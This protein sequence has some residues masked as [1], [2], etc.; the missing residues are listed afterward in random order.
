MTTPPL[1]PKPLPPNGKIAFI[2]PSNRI[3]YV[4]P[5]PLSRSRA[6]L[7]SLGYTVTIIFAPKGEEQDL[8]ASDGANIEACINNRLSEI[9][10]A[11]SDP[12][13]DAIFCTIGGSLMTELVPRLVRD[14]SLHDTVRRNPKI[15]VGYSDITILHWALSQT[16][17]LRTFYGPCPVTELGEAA[18][19]TSS[20]VASFPRRSVARS[21]DTDDGYLQDFNL[22]HLLRCLTSLSPLGPVPRSRFYA[23]LLPPYFF[24]F[25]K[26]ATAAPRSLLPSPPYTWLRPGRAEGLLFGGCLTILPRILS[27]PSL[28]PRSWA[29]KILFLESATADA[30]LSRGAPVAKIRQAVADI[31]AHGV[32]DEIAGL[33]VGRPYGY[34]TDAARAEY[35]AVFRGL[36]CRGRLAKRGFPILMNVDIGHTSPMVT[37]PFGALAALD[38][39][40]DRFEILEAGVAA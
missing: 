30:D 40:G 25:S 24:T 26:T 18:T 37:L 17:G 28:A 36:L 16:T 13:V 38:S 19:S 20:S 39:E 35:A 2:S 8:V 31:A 10:A 4:L 27:V 3:N 15:F 1:L 6:L 12:S 11:F 7:E 29:S 23:P 21:K 5:D 32:F 14:T 33:V 9:R 22:S 34:T